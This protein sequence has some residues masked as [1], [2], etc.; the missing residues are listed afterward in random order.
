ML[1]IL[2]LSFLVLLLTSIPSLNGLQSEQQQNVN[3]GG[4][5]R[6]SGQL[7]IPKLNKELS[8][9]STVATIESLIEEVEEKEEKRK[10]DRN[11]RRNNDDDE[12]DKSTTKDPKKAN[13]QEE[14]FS[15]LF[16]SR[17]RSRARL[18]PVRYTSR[19]RPTLPSFIRNTPTPRPVTFQPTY[20]QRTGERSNNRLQSSDGYNPSS[21]SRSGRLT[22]G[23]NGR[24]TTST[25][26]TTQRPTAATRRSRQ[27]DG[28][29]SNVSVVAPSSS[30]RGRF[31]SITPRN[32][33]RSSLTRTR[34]SVQLSRA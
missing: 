26:T 6:R 23:R 14:R 12:E 18:P 13:F 16:N 21:G 20:V 9:T 5:G 34:N 2:E 22:D 28:I 4:N 8:T 27:R 17:S 10:E 19:A 11:N 3:E 24:V 15:N 33:T 25:T 29:N 1:L 32:S 31:S 7:S 30:S